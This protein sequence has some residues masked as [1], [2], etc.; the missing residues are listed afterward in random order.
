MPRNRDPE[1]TPAVE[2]LEVPVAPEAPTPEEGQQAMER[3]YPRLKALKTVDPVSMDLR[4]GA[5]QSTKLLKLVSHPPVAA[6]MAE[7]SA[8]L[9]DPG[10]IAL[11]R[12][13]GHACYFT[14]NRNLIEEGLANERMVPVT[15]VVSATA[16][17]KRLFKL[18]EYWLDQDEAVEIA[19]IREGNG[20][21]DMS[22]DLFRLAAL[23]DKHRERLKA[24]QNLYRAEDA[25]EARQLSKAIVDALGEP[26]AVDDTEARLFTLLRQ[27]YDD[28]RQAAIFATRHSAPTPIFPSLHGIYH[29]GRRRKKKEEE[30]PQ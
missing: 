14:R 21:L 9:F 28:V 10:Q 23:V 15:L 29:S 7:Y 8:R 5:V 17:R 16:L 20:Y 26:D 13:L 2:P 1:N 3:L 6:L 12:D 19:S 22:S 25:A 4:D 18:V 27:T 11:L 30:G 24:D